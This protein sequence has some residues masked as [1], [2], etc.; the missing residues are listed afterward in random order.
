MVS[1]LIDEINAKALIG[2]DAVVSQTQNGGQVL[3][4]KQLES[5]DEQ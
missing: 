4:F 5:D 1:F 3:S 2:K